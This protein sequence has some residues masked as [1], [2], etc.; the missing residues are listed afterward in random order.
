MDRTDFSCRMHC[1]PVAKVNHKLPSESSNNECPFP[2]STDTN[3]PPFGWLTLTRLLVDCKSEAEIPSWPLKLLPHTK[4]SPARVTNTVCSKPQAACIIAV[5][6]VTI[7]FLL[8]CGF[9]GVLTGTGKGTALEE[10]R[11]QHPFRFSPQINT[12]PWADITAACPS[13]ADNSTKG[14]PISDGISCGVPHCEVS[15]WPA[16]VGMPHAKRDICCVRTSV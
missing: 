2:A 10:I 14:T 8:G 15:L 9:G 3:V 16:I 1:N 13:P 4:R 11:P 12:V 5:S 6:S 7:L